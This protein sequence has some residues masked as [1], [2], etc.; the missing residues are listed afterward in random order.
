MKSDL[1]MI[2]VETTNELLN[3]DLILAFTLPLSILDASNSI[4]FG[5]QERVMSFSKT[6]RRMTS[7]LRSSSIDDFTLGAF[8]YRHFVAPKLRC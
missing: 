7:T 4:D 8:A 6:V 1:A 2:I 5:Y 3:S